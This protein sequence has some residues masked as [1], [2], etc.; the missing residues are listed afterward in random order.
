MV[1][2]ELFGRCVDTHIERP[3]AHIS[4]IS[5]SRSTHTS[6]IMP[7]FLQSLVQVFI[8][9]CQ[10]VVA[11]IVATRLYAWVR[12]FLIEAAAVVVEEARSSVVQEAARSVF[13]FHVIFLLM[14]FRANARL[15]SVTNESCAAFFAADFPHLR[16]VLV[17]LAAALGWFLLIG[18]IKFLLEKAVS[19]STSLTR[20]FC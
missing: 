2:R 4:S 9:Y 15:V 14:I 8:R 18:I 6:Y 11:R 17:R 20:N 1:R 19:P 3:R 10:D 13:F 7:A 5:P 16:L 12:P